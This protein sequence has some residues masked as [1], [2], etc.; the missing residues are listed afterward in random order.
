MVSAARVR[1]ACD[2]WLAQPGPAARALT[3]LGSPDLD[4]VSLARGMGVPGERA[5]S[6]EDFATALGRAL[7]APGPYLI[8]A[9]L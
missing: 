9:V 4:W 5:D 6:A 8:E 2:L 3:D 7:A 1:L